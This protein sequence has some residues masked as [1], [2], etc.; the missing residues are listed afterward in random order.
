MPLIER[1]SV[2]RVYFWN[3]SVSELL[4]AKIFG[5]IVD[6]PVQV[7]HAVDGVQE[8]PLVLYRRSR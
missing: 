6:G 1:I 2:V 3:V 4:H 8:S 5:V 7:S